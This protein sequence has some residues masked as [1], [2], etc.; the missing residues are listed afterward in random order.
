MQISS[1]FFTKFFF[2][3]GQYQARRLNIFNHVPSYCLCCP[4]WE[5]NLR[6]T[7][8]KKEISCTTFTQSNACWG[9]HVWAVI[10]RYPKVRS[11]FDLISS[12]LAEP[13]VKCAIPK[14][15]ILGLKGQ[16]LVHDAGCK[17]QLSSKNSRP[18]WHSTQI[19]WLEI[20]EMIALRVF[21]VPPTCELHQVTYWPQVI[22]ISA[23]F[24]T[25][26][27]LLNFFFRS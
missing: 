13:L 26:S 12:S 4:F 17:E 11:K 21:C 19:F 14:Y 23:H 3:P 25:A 10:T 27:S 20:V 9:A 16:D 18:T 2:L 22:L 24:P 1:C 7:A 15:D 8:N 6:R 5:K